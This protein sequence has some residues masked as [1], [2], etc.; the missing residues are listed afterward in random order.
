MLALT[1]SD[2][3]SKEHKQRVE[4]YGEI[5]MEQ[6][7]FTMTHFFVGGSRCRSMAKK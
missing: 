4:K 1:A 3:E 7:D 2:P 5:D 6:E